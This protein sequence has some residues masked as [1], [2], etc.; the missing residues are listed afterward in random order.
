MKYH[1]TLI[2]LC[3]AL[4]IGWAPI[5]LAGAG[6]EAAL[7]AK[8][9]ERQA[10][11]EDE[12]REAIVE[13]EQ[14]QQA[15][16][17]SVA[18]AQERQHRAA[19]RTQEASEE[20]QRAEAARD[21]ELAEMHEELNR[22]RREL[23]ETSREVARVSRE[24]ARA[25]SHGRTD[26][27]FVYMS[28]QKPVIGVVLG[29]ST[30]AG[31]EI[32][33]VSPD[34]PAE[35]AGIEQGD[36]LVA[37]GEH[38]LGA[39]TDDDR[40]KTALGQLKAGDAV[41]VT[42]QRNDKLVD[43]NVVPEVREP[44][45]W[46]TVTRFPSAPESPE[47]VIRIE[48]IVVPELDTTEL[49]ERIANIKIE[50]AERARLVAPRVP[51]APPAPE[52]YEFEFHELSE[53]GDTALWETNV[54]FGLPMTRGLKLAE[55]APGLGEYFETE[56]G[57]LVLKARENNELQLESGDVILDVGETE[58]NSPVEFMRALRELEPGEEIALEI[59]R[60]GKSKTLKTTMP[61]RKLG[62]FF[63]G[64]DINH[65]LHFNYTTD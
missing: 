30:K 17:A 52:D 29:D 19:E 61:E 40:L 53:L 59:K 54:W 14:R 16:Q 65:T 45:G 21:A 8:E 18:R 27:R 48:S 20:R 24:V 3:T 31:I 7:Q 56:R 55:M 28:T 38:E 11:L 43:V 42:Y 6:E 5:T 50:V 13:A 57:V 1:H 32:I 63:P 4:L 26:S 33:G 46:H 23:Q 37:L 9:A 44:L 35:R 39:G 15:A 62:L 12:Y 2:T 49:A 47:D 34:G 58:V 51:G 22:T 60:S 10:Q 36:I 41:V 25:R 64:Q